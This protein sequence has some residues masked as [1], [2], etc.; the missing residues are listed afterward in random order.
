[1]A[2]E[3]NHKNIIETLEHKELEYEKIRSIVEE[4][5]DYPRAKKFKKFLDALEKRNDLEVTVAY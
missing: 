1:M 2:F 3:K 5:E 4:A